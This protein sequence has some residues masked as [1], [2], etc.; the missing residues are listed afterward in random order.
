MTAIG[1]LSAWAETIESHRA[2][3]RGSI[4]D[5]ATAAQYE[6]D[7]K[8]KLDVIALVAARLDP[9]NARAW[10]ALGIAFGDALCL[11]TGFH[12]GEV[13]DEYGTDPVIVIN[14]AAHACAFPMT[15]LS[16]R[17]EQGAPPDRE[18]I[19]FLFDQVVHQ[20]RELAATRS[21]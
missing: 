5:A 7:W 3:V 20:A 6:V 21:S 1:P 16:K 8:T 12:W 19:R 2:W 17:A 14:A 15:M 4:S 9:A 11:A 13:T 10:Q 18:T